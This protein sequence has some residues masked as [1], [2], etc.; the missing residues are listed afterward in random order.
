MIKVNR[1]LVWILLAAG[2]VLAERYG[3]PVPTLLG[4]GFAAV[5]AWAWYNRRRQERRMEAPL[6]ASPDGLVTVVRMACAHA[7]LP[8]LTVVAVSADRPYINLEHGE[9]RISPDMVGLLTEGE[10]AALILFL[11]A[12]GHQPAWYGRLSA[13]APLLL[14]V[15]LPLAMTGVIPVWLVLPAV[16]VLLGW[17][18][19]RRLKPPA[20]TRPGRAAYREF[21]ER[22]GSPIDYLRATIKLHRL[23]LAAVAKPDDRVVFIGAAWAHFI[24]LADMAKLPKGTADVLMAEVGATAEFIPTQVS[25]WRRLG[26]LRPFVAAAGI[27]LVMLVLMVWVAFQLMSPVVSAQ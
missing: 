5:V 25:A 7:G 18:V 3:L 16:V 17:A 6:P 15:A 12:L 27:F 22:G 21:L 2:I 10:L 4:V 1:F 20:M 26:G 14:V 19:A 24:A 23:S 13:A 8:Q 9:V 11:H